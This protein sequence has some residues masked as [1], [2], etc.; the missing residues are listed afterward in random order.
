M[1]G[2]IEERSVKKKRDEKRTAPDTMSTTTSAFRNEHFRDMVSS[3]KERGLSPRYVLLTVG[4]VRLRTWSRFV[5][6]ALCGWEVTSPTG[7]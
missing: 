7:R 1:Y 6:A 4:T 2:N 5:P 3:A